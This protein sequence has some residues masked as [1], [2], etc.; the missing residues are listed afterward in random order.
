MKEICERPILDLEDLLHDPTTRVIGLVGDKNQGK[1]GVLYA[2]CDIIKRKA[3]ETKIV[4]FRMQ[5]SFPGMLMLNDMTELS[6]VRNSVIHLDELKTFVDTD[7]RTEFNDFMSILQTINHPHRNNIIILSG[8]AHNFNGKLSGE[9][10]VVI[11][12]Q[13]TMISII[14]R[15]MLDNILKGF[16]Q[17]GSITKDKYMLSME[18]DEALI[19]NPKMEKRWHNITVPYLKQYDVKRDN[20]PVIKWKS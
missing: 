14:K 15:S 19:Y 4:G 1:S 16:K 5:A 10:D 3:P 6:L 2:I 13:T 11:F 7:N 8:L 20:E 18:K 12:K 17:Q 9:L